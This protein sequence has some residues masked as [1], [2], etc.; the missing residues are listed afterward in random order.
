MDVVEG[1]RLPNEEDDDEE[2]NLNP[3]IADQIFEELE[4]LGEHDD[5][6]GDLDLVDFSKCFN[7]RQARGLPLVEM[8]LLLSV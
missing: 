3:L 6:Q 5:D 4:E 1:A 2:M 7:L 8:S